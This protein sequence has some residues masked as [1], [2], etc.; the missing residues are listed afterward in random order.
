VNR[1]G[2]IGPMA[3]DPERRRAGVGR[4][5][6]GALCADLAAQRLAEAEIAWVGPIG[7]YAKAGARVSRVFRT[8]RLPL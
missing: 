4:A 1:H 3:T 7:F 6:L 2:W 8:A 5:L